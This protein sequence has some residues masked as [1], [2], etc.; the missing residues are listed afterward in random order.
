ITAI[1]RSI[2]SC[3]PAIERRAEQVCGV[4]ISGPC[5][6]EEQSVRS[7]DSV[8]APCRAGVNRN[9]EHAAT[10][11]GPDDIGGRSSDRTKLGIGMHGL[12]HEL[13]VE[14]RWGQEQERDGGTQHGCSAVMVSG[15]EFPDQS[16]PAVTC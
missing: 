10:S 8:R 13:A 6:R 9:N 2:D 12:M 3:Q 15:T 14:Y 5:A 11:G 4:A 7:C 16:S 1:I